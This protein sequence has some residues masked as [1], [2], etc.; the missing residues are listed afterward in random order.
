MNKVPIQIMDLTTLKAVVYELSQDI[1][2]S[3]FENA[4]QIDSHT[5]QLG[6]R[7]LENLIWIEISWLAESPRIVEIPPPKRYGE[8]STLAKQI[9]YLLANLALVEIKQTGFE[10]IVRFKLSSRPGKEIEKELIVELMGRH[11]NILLLDNTSKVITLGKQIKDYQSRLR[12]IGTGDI[13]TSPPPLKGLVPQLSESFNSWKDNICLVPST[14]KNSLKNT[15]QGIS[16]AL[17]LQIASNNYDEAFKII[18]QP[19]TNIELKTWEALYQK[20]KDWLLDIEKNNYTIN[21]EGPT[22]FIVWGNRQSKVKERKI[23]ISLS[24]YYSKKIEE[25]KINSIREKLKQDLRNSKENELRKLE[26]QE[27]L[28]NN[29]SE[30]ITMQNKANKLLTLQSPSKKQIIEAQILFKEAKRKKRS[31]ESILNRIE[32]HKKKISDIEHCELF[33]DLLTYKK[34]DYN[35]LDSIIE[36]KEEVEAYICIKKPT[37][38]FKSKKRKEQLSKIKEIQS[39]NG[40]KIQIGGNNRQNELISLKQGKKGDIWFHAQEIP[41]SHVVLKSSNGLIDDK[42][43]Q[44][45]ADLASFF[46]RAKGSKLIPVIMVPIENLQRISGA[47]PGTVRHRGGKV[48]WGKAERAQKYFHQK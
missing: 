16:P 21:F 34:V 11:S 29:I 32:F 31:K 6:F 30:Y 26:S 23:G 27:L 33:L 25:R 39:P 2:P 7:T 19:V 24:M 22:D 20:W 9:K 3:R 37:T 4:Q 45:A 13:Y 47:L 17:V 5:I 48:L 46:S 41:G 15:Y 14:F 8:K 12:P 40:V 10:R 1:V 35:K 36:L 44:L 28:I 38:K 43:I 42:D 18:N